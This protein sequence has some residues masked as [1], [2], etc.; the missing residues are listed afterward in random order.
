MRSDDVNHPMTEPVRDRH[1]THARVPGGE[2]AVGE[3]VPVARVVKARQV[4]HVQLDSL[5]G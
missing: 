1:L 2:L 3:G 4:L 5:L